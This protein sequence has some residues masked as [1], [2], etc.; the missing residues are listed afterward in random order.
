MKKGIRSLLIGAVVL[1]F[2][3]VAIDCAITY[4]NRNDG[5]TL[6]RIESAI[7]N[8]PRWEI[9]T[10]DTAFSQVNQILDQPWYY[11]GCGFQ[12]FAFISQDG[13]YVLKFLRHQ[14]LRP[15]TLYDLLPSIPF[16]LEQKEKKTKT[17][18]ARV[19]QLFQSLKIAVER[20]PHETG[21]LFV[22][23]NKTLSHHPAVTIHDKCGDCYTISLDDREFILQEKAQHIKPV[24]AKL[25]EEG[26][27]DQAK[28][29]L[30]QIVDLLTVCAKRGVLDLD[31]ALIKK[32]NLGFLQDRAIYI[33][34]GKFVEVEKVTLD[35]FKRDL[36]RLRPLYK[37]LMYSHPFLANHLERRQKQAID[38]FVE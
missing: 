10:S 4:K 18:Q 16:V 23:L 20:V 31:R 25:M 9:N 6:E 1:A 28:K 34:A 7:P 19:E 32:D 8:D 26:K 2:L 12:C 22:H 17:R 5:F 38:S 11:L 15:P 3:Y 37:W 24:I 13:K 29:R 36:T 14:R 33:D 35:Q 27:V 21:I 30:D